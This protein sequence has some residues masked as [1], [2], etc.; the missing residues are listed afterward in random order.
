MDW[1]ASSYTYNFTCVQSAHVHVQSAKSGRVKTRPA[2]LFAT[3]MY[4]AW[5][6]TCTALRGRAL[7]RYTLTFIF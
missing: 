5:F 4:W 1:L 3:A 7:T 6:N 2:R